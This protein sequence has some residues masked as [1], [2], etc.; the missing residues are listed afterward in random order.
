MVSHGTVMGYE[1]RHGL[2]RDRKIGML[3]GD[4]H[5]TSHCE[6]HLKLRFFVL[7]H[8]RTHIFRAPQKL[9]MQYTN[10][11]VIWICPINLLDLG[12]PG[13]YIDLLCTIWT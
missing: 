9:S 3:A 10:N 7:M 5:I 8:L 13:I 12:V 6:N 2:R 1:E 11:V 4:T